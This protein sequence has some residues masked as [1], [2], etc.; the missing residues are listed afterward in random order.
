[1]KDKDWLYRSL[2][3]ISFLT[4]VSGLIQMAAPGFILRLLS[5]ET[6]P[7]ALHFFSIV[8]MFMTLFGGAFLN[9]LLSPEHHPIVVFWASLQKLGA[10]AAVGLGVARHIFSPLALAVAFFDL[11][12]GVLGL[13]YWMKI[14]RTS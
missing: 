1:M 8:G 4:A 3:V 9:A 14:K 13:C 11:L 12:T 2:A 6:T 5:A 10:F 7:A